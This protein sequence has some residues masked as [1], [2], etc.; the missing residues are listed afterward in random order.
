MKF[1]PLLLFFAA[2]LLF[3]CTAQPN[4]SIPGTTESETTSSIDDKTTIILSEYYGSR[5]PAAELIVGDQKQFA[6]LGTSTWTAE[7]SGDES[8]IIHGDAFGLVTPNEPMIVDSSF[9]A[10]LLLPIPSPIELWYKLIRVT[11]DLTLYPGKET[12]TWQ[13]GVKEP[14]QFIPLEKQQEI[15]FTLVQG[16]Y[17]LEVCT[18]WQDLGS[19]YYGFYLEVKEID[20][21]ELIYVDP[22]AQFSLSL[23]SGWSISDDEGFFTGPVSTLRL[24]YLPEMAFTFPVNR[25][26]QRLANTSIGPAYQIQIYPFGNVEACLLIPYPQL[27]TSSAKIVV[28]NPNGEPEQRYFYLESDQETLEALT[29]SLKLLNPAAGREPFPYPTGSMRAEDVTFWSQVRSAPV[30]L[31]AEEHAVV[32][33][34]VDSPV[35]F[36]FLRH[37]PEKILDKRAAWRENPPEKRIANNNLLLQ[38]LGLSLE[39]KDTAEMTLYELYQGDELLLDEISHAWP[40]SISSGGSSAVLTVE[41]WNDGYRLVHL[42]N[43]EI[44]I[45][46]WD[47]GS[48]LFFPPVNQGE[49][50]LTL[51]W[52]WNVNE[53]QVW[54]GSRRIY[55]FASLFLVAPPVHGLWS[56]HDHW[57]VEIDGFLI[58]DGM[59]LNERL[60]FDEAFGWQ[61]LNGKPFYFFRKGPRVGI[62]YDGQVLPYYYEDVPHYRC[63][64]PAMFNKAGNEDMV[65]FYGLRDGIWYYVEVGIFTD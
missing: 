39:L 44:T 60:G 34:S 47:M 43:G 31:T 19:I 17:L 52:D 64:E 56:W 25:V 61:L 53:V 7:K 32:E 46:E 54:S 11:D 50:L 4:Q 1:H 63:C 49:E 23:P 9:T 37:I 35:R 62:V 42:F 40:V 26:C 36:E 24:S 33:N 8:T 41:I 15:S 10:T 12:I 28:E 29:G 3:A 5:P 20:Q 48:S 65:W 6:S 45:N 55:S 2:F 22:E 58:Q 27:S 16:K 30:E 13:A 14:R 38:P 21:K 51:R 57:L 18:E 59:N